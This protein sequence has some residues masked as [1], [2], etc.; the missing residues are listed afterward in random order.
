[1]RTF[2]DSP[3][4]TLHYHV[5]ADARL[6]DARDLGWNPAVMDSPIGPDRRVADLDGEAR[7]PATRQGNMLD[8]TAI[9]LSVFLVALVFA[10]TYGPLRVLL[11]VAFAFFV[12]GRAIVGN[13][14]RMGQWSEAAMSMVLS[15]A[16]LV[17]LTTVMLWIHAWHP[18]GLFQIIAGLSIVALIISMSRRHR[19]T[20]GLGR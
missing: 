11:A 17:V 9:L 2:M 19:R 5:A 3:L 10:G 20:R 1:M 8:V 14:P 12:P 13:W 6:V 4:A 18:L 15:L 7:Q 16:V